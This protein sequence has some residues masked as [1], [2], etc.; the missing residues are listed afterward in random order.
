MRERQNGS[1]ATLL[2]REAAPNKQIH[3]YVNCSY[4]ISKASILAIHTPRQNALACRSGIMTR[5]PPSIR[6]PA[7]SRFM[8]AAGCSNSKRKNDAHKEKN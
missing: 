2:W 1:S 3:S 6:R 4:S 8:M 5:C 7:P